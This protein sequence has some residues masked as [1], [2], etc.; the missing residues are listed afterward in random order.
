MRGAVGDAGVGRAIADGVAETIAGGWWWHLQAMEGL[1]LYLGQWDGTCTPLGLCQP[2]IA[3]NTSHPHDKAQ[4]RHHSS[5]HT[6][7]AIGEIAQVREA[8]AC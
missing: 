4:R 3:A 5:K 8:T 7:E 2:R 6:N 1:R